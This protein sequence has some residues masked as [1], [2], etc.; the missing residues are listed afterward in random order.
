MFRGSVLTIARRVG[1]FCIEVR[2]VCFDHCKAC[3]I[4]LCRSLEIMLW[5]L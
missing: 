5:L 1:G 4:E 3:R 2:R